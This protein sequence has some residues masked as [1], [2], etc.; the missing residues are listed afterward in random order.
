MRIIQS[1]AVG[2][3]LLGMLAGSL[4]LVGFVLKMEASPSEK[5]EWLVAEDL[6][7]LQTAK[8]LPKEFGALGSIERYGGTPRARLWLE[9]LKWPLKTHQQGTHD[10]EILVVDWVEG[11]KEGVLIQYNLTDKASGNMVW[12]LGRTFILKDQ[13]SLYYR[14][15]PHLMNWLRH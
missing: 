4:T 10:L 5:L 1:L 8:V 6:K 15:R 2:L 13:S 12:E 7:N 11:P 14:L 3:I 9:K